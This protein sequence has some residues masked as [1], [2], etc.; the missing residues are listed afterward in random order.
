M[1]PPG[2]RVVAV[3]AVVAAAVVHK[4]PRVRFPE[5]QIPKLRRVAGGAGTENTSNTLVATS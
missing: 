5:G 3:V 2:M 1:L 4:C